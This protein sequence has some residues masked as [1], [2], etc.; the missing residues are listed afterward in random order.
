[1]PPGFAEIQLASGLDPTAMEFSPDGRLF[2][3]EKPG[4]V[5][6]MKNDLLLATPFVT[7]SADNQNERGLSGIAFD[8]GFAVNGHIY[9]YYTVL[10]GSPGAAT[11]NRVVRVTADPSD[12]D[13][14]ISGSETTIL[15]LDPISSS[16]NI[17]MGGGLFFREGKL[18]IGTGEA[19]VGSRSQSF[20]SLMGKMLRINPDG[21]IP[22]DNPFYHTTSGN[23]RAIYALGLRNPFSF[24]IQAGSGMVYLND[25]GGHNG[26]YEEINEL[27]PAANYGWPH[28]EGSA[29]IGQNGYQNPVHAYPPGSHNNGYAI[30]GGTFYNPPGT[31]PGRF[32]AGYTGLYFF[33]DYVNRWVKTYN[34]A[35]AEV[36]GFSTD[37]HRPITGSA[38][39]ARAGTD[40]V[41]DFL[42]RGGYRGRKWLEIGLTAEVSTSTPFR[43]R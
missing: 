20:S 17:H 11:H 1:L 36:L 43:T 27:L 30:C 32:P 10:N 42:H 19:G 31:G 21:S 23:Y 39:R 35:T 26:S 40:T 28:F 4:R 9:L 34:P 41:S 2:I 15:D 6:I 7:V 38:A 37:H 29:P 14:A 18:Y 33:G 16:N 24:D 12:P 25:V 3:L 8:P 22:T 13:R 5:R